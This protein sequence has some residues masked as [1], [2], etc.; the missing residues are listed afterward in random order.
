[1]FVDVA[2]SALAGYRSAEEYGRRERDKVV[3]EAVSCRSWKMFSNFK[4]DCQVKSPADGKTLPKVGLD[5]ARRRDQKVLLS[6][7]ASIDAHVIGDSMRG[8]DRKP[9]ADP[10]P[11]VDDRGRAQQLSDERDDPP[12]RSNSTV[13]P[14][15]RNGVCVRPL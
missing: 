2:Q 11:N 15:S 8:E 13:A 9:G 14:V 7:V 6:D 12:R 1:L 10:T 3:D 4:R 5:E